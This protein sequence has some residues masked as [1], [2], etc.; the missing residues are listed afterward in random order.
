MKVW[1]DDEREAP[2]GWERAYWP[3]EVVRF[4]KKGQVE[5]LSLDHDLGNDRRGTGYDVLLWI[6]KAVATKGFKPPK[7]MR[8]HS[9]N[10]GARGKMEQAIEAIYRI[11][12]TPKPRKLGYIGVVLEPS[13]TKKLITWWMNTVSPLL[14]KVE[15]HHMTIDFKPKAEDAA[16]FPLGEKVSLQVIGWAA[17]D[18]VQAVAVKSPHK[19][20]KG[21]PEHIT[22]ATAAGASPKEAGPLLARGYERVRGPSFTGRVGVYVGGK[23]RYTEEELFKRKDRLAM[24]VAAQHTGNLYLNIPPTK[25]Q[26]MLKE[27]TDE[28]KRRAIQKALGAWRETHTWLAPDLRYAAFHPSTFPQSG[29]AGFLFVKDGKMLLMKRSEGVSDPGKWGIP[30][31]AVSA[32]DQHYLAAATRECDEE[33][34]STPHMTLLDQNLTVETED[35]ESGYVRTYKVF[36]AKP[37]EPFDPELN[38]EHDEYG[39]FSY[40]EAKE[41]PLQ[42]MLWGVMAHMDPTAME[43]QADR[44]AQKWAKLSP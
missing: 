3:D 26:R 12:Y 27:E 41:L 7:V 18:K 14:P 19:S 31:G 24:R 20:R 36:V 34:G 23:V 43:E 29:G 35:P 39:W 37:E 32:E 40:H 4:L 25:L 11:Y 17:D 22:V 2:S 13:S 6:E 42:G 8:V 33:C 28:K 21:V 1:L 44:I 9:A 16:E 30:G 5:E 15:S 38:W 10:A